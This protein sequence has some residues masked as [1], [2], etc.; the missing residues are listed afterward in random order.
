M[1]RWKEGY[2]RLTGSQSWGS[3]DYVNIKKSPGVS[4]GGIKAGKSYPVGKSE[5]HG[6]ATLEETQYPWF[7]F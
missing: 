7:D 4:K 2:P 3:E 6:N 5:S 1:Q